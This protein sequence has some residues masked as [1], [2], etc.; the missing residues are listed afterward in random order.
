M[1]SSKGSKLVVAGE[2]GKVMSSPRPA[3]SWANPTS[4]GGQGGAFGGAVS[5]YP[6]IFAEVDDVPNAVTVFNAP[7]V[8]FSQTPVADER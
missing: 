2:G 4:T 7:G 8:G 1:R 6:F 5:H 3:N